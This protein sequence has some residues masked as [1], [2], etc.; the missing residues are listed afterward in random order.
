MFISRQDQRGVEC[1]VCGGSDHISRYC[2]L[3]KGGLGKE[4]EGI[5]NK[6]INYYGKGIDYS[7]EEEN[8]KRRKNGLQI[9]EIKKMYPTIFNDGK[10][11]I[12]FEMGSKCYIRRKKNSE[13]RTMYTTES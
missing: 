11:T 5:E 13:K 7:E 1:Y 9:E 4:N 3:R 8:T 6:N 12:K 2:S 10:G